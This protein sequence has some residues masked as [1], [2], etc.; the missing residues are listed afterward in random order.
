M[1]HPTQQ[2]LTDYAVG[3]L[4]E[5]TLENVARHLD[6]CQECQATIAHLRLPDDTFVGKVRNVQATPG[7]K[8]RHAAQANVAQTS[9]QSGSSAQPS[10]R[11][12]KT[13]TSSSAAAGNAVQ[14]SQSSLG[15]G[16]IGAGSAQ[17]GAVAV[18]VS[19]PELSSALQ[20]LELASAA[21][22]STIVGRLPADKRTDPQ[23]V[24][25]LLVDDKK[26]TRFQAQIALSGKAKA[27]RF[28]DYIVLDRI[29]A[30]GM[31]HVYRARHRRMDRIVAL[32][33]ISSAALKSADS[34]ERFKREVKAAAKLMHANIVTAFDA[35]DQD[36]AHYLVMEFVD[37]PD[38]ASK[39]RQAKFTEKQVV[40]YLG[41]AARGLAFA[42]SKG[43]VHRDIKPGNLL[44]D[45]EGT[46][47]ILDMGLARFDDPS[48][49]ASAQAEAGLTQ[50]GQVMGTIDYMAPE[51]ALN[52]S[53]A[54]GKSDVYSLGCTLYRLLTGENVYGGTTIVEKILA[55]R[56]QPIPS[57]RKLRPDVSTALDMLFARLVAKRPE[58]RLSMQEAVEAFDAIAKG[59]ALPGASGLS[60]VGL[61]GV[62]LPS[63]SLPPPAASMAPPLAAS[64]PQ[65]SS[66]SASMQPTMLP[67]ATAYM[68]QPTA[69]MPGVPAAM[70]YG[71]APPQAP[72]P[73][74]RASHKPP[75]RGNGPLIALAAAAGA[76]A[77]CAGV[78]LYI[79]DKDG[80][81]KMAVEIQPGDTITLGPDSNI[82]VPTATPSATPATP[83]ATATPTTAPWPPTASVA[84][85]PSSPVTTPPQQPA[86]PVAGPPSSA[87]DGTD[88]L[89]LIDVARDTQNTKWKYAAGVAQMDAGGDSGYAYVPLE[90][91]G[92]Y[93][94]RA[95]ITIVRAKSNFQLNLPVGVERA[96]QLR[97][98]GDNGDTE[99]PTATVSLRGLT[100]Q[101][102]PLAS[103]TVNSGTEYEYRVRVQFRTGKVE[104]NVDLDGKPLFQWSNVLGQVASLTK[105]SRPKTVHFQSGYYSIGKISELK[106][107]RLQ[108]VLGPGQ[109]AVAAAPSQS[110]WQVPPPLAPGQEAQ[111]RPGLAGMHYMRQSLAP[112]PNEN[113][114][115]PTELGNPS[116]GPFVASTIDVTTPPDA[117]VVLSGYLKVDVPGEYV[118]NTNSA[119]D[120]NY[121]LLD[122]EVV[123]KFRDGERHTSTITLEKKYYSVVAM[124]YYYWKRSTTLAV[125]WQPPGTTELVSIPASQ[126]FHLPSAVPGSGMIAGATGNTG[127]PPPGG[128]PPGEIDRA[129][130][131]PFTIGGASAGST[132][133]RQG[134][135]SGTTAPAARSASGLASVLML[136]P[137]QAPERRLKDL[138]VTAPVPA[139]LNGAKGIA[140]AVKMGSPDSAGGVIE[141]RVQNP[142]KIYVAVSWVYDGG[143]SPDEQ[144]ER[145]DEAKLREMGFTEAGKTTIRMPADPAPQKPLDDPHTVYVRDCVV[146]DMFRIRTRRFRPPVLFVADDSPADAAA[147]FGVPAATSTGAVP[148]SAPSVATTP[149][150]SAP[151]PVT[152][153]TV[154]SAAPV[155]T[156][157]TTVASASSGRATPA[158]ASLAPPKNSVP[159]LVGRMNFGTQDTGYYLTYTPGKVFRHDVIAPLLGTKLDEAL[160]SRRIKIVLMGSLHVPAD[161]HVIVWHG[162]GTASGGVHR[163]KI[164]DNLLGS[165]G[166][167]RSKNS[168][169]TVPL[170]KGNHMVEWE[171]TGGDLGNSVAA[172]YKAE[173]LEPLTVFAPPN[174]VAA[175]RAVATTRD[176]DNSSDQG[177]PPTPPTLVA[178]G[179]TVVTPP[180]STGRGN[181]PLA[182][183]GATPRQIAE[184]VLTL[185]G[186]VDL[187]IGGRVARI[188]AMNELP[189]AGELTITSIDL[190]EGQTV[191]DA[192]LP[193]FATLP[194]LKR[195]YVQGSKITGAGLAALT[196]LPE[197]EHLRLDR[198]V[199][200]DSAMDH[201]GKMTKLKYLDVAF[202]QVTD[203]GLAKLS[204]LSQLETLYFQGN[205]VTPAGL[206]SLLPLEKLNNVNLDET[207]VDDGA[208]AVLERFP[209]MRSVSLRN[210]LVTDA[211]AT[212][213]MKMPNIRSVNLHGTRFTQAAV[214]KVKAVLPDSNLKIR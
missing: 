40:D 21:E 142:G 11:Q 184:R 182:F 27:L 79:K 199:L 54:T 108:S 113:G 47:K 84:T 120:R 213:F 20:E 70:P 3:K 173:N 178:A 214:D 194:R 95:R 118:F 133:I 131:Q 164:D 104:V 149:V 93:E 196:G 19:L 137:Y 177:L 211:S 193:A 138:F 107:H 127:G 146:G 98:Q 154:A 6:D 123:C 204:N 189:I 41:Q 157:A 109:G 166:D 72:H 49:A 37:G 31:G 9:A 117:S 200:N 180:A 115:E 179:P 7:V 170:A 39:L 46:V 35:G 191:T 190:D 94:V 202:S 29:G 85:I 206:S 14:V 100:P 71:A 59:T 130:P 73:V 198:G 25:K 144:R 112:I 66:F 12:P 62:G 152:P 10:A 96:I 114:V 212:H 38:L 34:V 42:H 162:G 148:V 156:P 103:A 153:T 165:I 69:N 87:T 205:R 122:G 192:D 116:G 197:L 44:V 58:Q 187:D 1:K 8:T 169:Y 4:A 75:R 141:F 33:V 201:V 143:L 102:S 128:P 168:V 160:Q 207:K 161:M 68:Q 22:L 82:V 16:K 101:P 155:S 76:A 163:L 99:A 67:Q 18:N 106:L 83:V 195:I 97:F 26:L 30:G 52:T 88:L 186:S 60:G 77:I 86:V 145:V 183:V 121:F 147:T 209:N 2:Q 15:G 65:P 188:S 23:A 151:V 50:H 132:T 159:H 63:A 172:F 43:V 90:L 129:M 150:P 92:S 140:A 181:A 17:P 32:K 167:D 48:D 64:L 210:T 134:V 61:S 78:W 53:A 51:Q 176:V 126:L 124:S 135:L 139:Y 175:A 203:A 91:V 158:S 81:T 80:K 56:E 36:G 24:V 119:W 74:V 105:A 89:P 5:A 125:K 208:V 136:V 174:L 185:R 45:S 28:G 110:K 57:L 111:L 13:A 171:L 55:H